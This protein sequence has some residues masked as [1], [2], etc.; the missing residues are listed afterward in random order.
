MKLLILCT[1]LVICAPLL[2]AETI[3]WQSRVNQEANR[4]G[5]RV[6]RASVVGQQLHG[7]VE[8]QRQ[9]S[10]LLVEMDQP[11]HDV[12]ET[13]GDGDGRQ[14]GHSVH[15]QVVGPL[16]SFVAAIWCALLDLRYIR[17]QMAVEERELYR[18]TLGDEAFRK[19]LREAQEEQAAERKK[20]QSPH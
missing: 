20:S 8:G 10:E 12:G 6:D 17:V 19:A 14:R 3:P 18:Q 15:D 9:R 7:V 4:L 1:A 2:R 11:G 16:L 13:V 5:H